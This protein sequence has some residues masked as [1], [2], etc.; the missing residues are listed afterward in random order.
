M[1]KAI[2]SRHSGWFSLKGNIIS[3]IDVHAAKH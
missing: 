1:C 2:W 3:E